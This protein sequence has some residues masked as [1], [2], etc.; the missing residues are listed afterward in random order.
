MLLFEKNHFNKLYDVSGMTDNFL[1]LSSAYK[2]Q[3]LGRVMTS[4]NEL[5]TY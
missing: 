5:Q 3:Y 1:C 4:L 2:L